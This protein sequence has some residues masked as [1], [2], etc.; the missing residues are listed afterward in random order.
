MK[1]F[2]LEFKSFAT[3]GNAI[4]LAIGVMIGAAF[5][6]IIDSLVADLF[7]PV[8]SF[9]TGGQINY[10]NSFITLS[11]VPEGIPMTLD[12]LRKAGVNVL[13]WGNFVSIILNFIILAFIVFV[14]MKW[15]ASLKQADKK[16]Q[17]TPEVVIPEDIALLREIRDALKRQ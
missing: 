7:L 8:I 5:G 17:S 1:N 2:L 15:L 10:A 4:D 3:K 13:A 6:K 14:M 9:I 12:A 16:V 11:P